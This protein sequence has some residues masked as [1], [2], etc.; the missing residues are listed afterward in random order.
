MMTYSPG[1][2]MPSPK[3][4]TL[5]AAQFS[6]TWLSPEGRLVSN[7]DAVPEERVTA[8]DLT[9][10]AESVFACKEQMWLYRQKDLQ[11]AL[12]EDAAAHERS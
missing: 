7:R 3:A 9:R 5:R 2:A 4:Q 12:L 8:E 10:F 11:N 1:S 6:H